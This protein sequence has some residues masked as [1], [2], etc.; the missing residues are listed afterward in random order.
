MGQEFWRT[1]LSGS[2]LESLMWLQVDCSL[3]WISRGLEQLGAGWACFSSYTQVTSPSRFNGRGQRLPPAPL[4]LNRRGT[5]DA[6][7]L[8]FFSG[9]TKWCLTSRERLCSPDPW[10]VFPPPKGSQSGWWLQQGWLWWQWVF[11]F[12]LSWA[13]LESEVVGF[14]NCPSQSPPLNYQALGGNSAISY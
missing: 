9:E 8:S 7:V 11:S 4:P 12:T 13:P 6:L 3:S 2:G 14:V 5:K 10:A 1:W